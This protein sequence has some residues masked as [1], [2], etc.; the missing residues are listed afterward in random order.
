MSTIGASIRTG[1]ALCGLGCA[2]ALI[3]AILAG[4]L[5]AEDSATAEIWSKEVA[6]AAPTG[7]APVPAEAVAS[8]E[9]SP[10]SPPMVDAPAPSTAI[11]LPMTISTPASGELRA[12]PAAALPVP[13]NLTAAPAPEAPVPPTTEEIPIVANAPSAPPPP[14]PAAQPSLTT[15]QEYQQD[16][17]NPEVNQYMREQ[18]GIV[19]PQQ[20]HDLRS[21]MAEGAFTSPIGLELQEARKKLDS[22]EEAEGLLIVDVTKGSPAANA[23]LHAYS[24]TGRNVATGAA[25]AAAMF[26][27][28]AIL[29]VPL[30]DYSNVGESYDMIIGVDGSRVSNYLDFEDRLHDLRPGEIVYLSVVRNGQ[31]RQV[32]V[33]VPPTS[34]LT[35]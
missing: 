32:K 2:T 21:F 13:S 24:R 5:Y 9:P 25:L 35:W 17:D 10:S 29:A 1:R 22:G 26:F 31:R 8:P 16:M 11:S 14:Q 34:T 28:P 27:P 20:F 23:G 7:A 3:A 19:D 4:P 15:T 30:I 33:Y 12:E 6:S 18:S